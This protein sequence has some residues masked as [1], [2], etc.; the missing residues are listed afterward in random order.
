VEEQ[1][2][3]P[4]SQKLFVLKRKYEEERPDPKDW[5]ITRYEKKALLEG[6]IPHFWIFER[7]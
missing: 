4:E 6:R 1:F 7:V 5:P 2:K 3:F